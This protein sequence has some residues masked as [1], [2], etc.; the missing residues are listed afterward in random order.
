M[1]RFAIV[2]LTAGLI[3][4]S[5]SPAARAEEASADSVSWEGRMVALYPATWTQ[6]PGLPSPYAAPGGMET[7]TAV[8][9]DG[10]FT[11]VPVTLT[12]AQR[13]VDGEDFPVLAQTGLHDDA[14][15][16]QTR[17]ITG[18]TVAEITEL[19]K[20]GG[21][22]GSGFLAEDED[23]VS[24]LLADNRIV[25]GLGLT[26]P[27]L[28][29][30]LFH[31]I[32]VLDLDVGIVWRNH[33]WDGLEGFLYHGRMV[34]LKGTGTKG[35]QLSIFDDGIKGA[36]AIDFRRE[37]DPGEEAF[38]KSRYGQLPEDAF[39]HLVE[40]LS[41]VLTGEMEPQYIMRYG[42]YEGHTEWRTDPIALAFVFGLA[43]L[44]EIETAFPGRLDRVLTARF[45]SGGR[46][47][48]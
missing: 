47:G 2:L 15:L 18:R 11:V 5:V 34:R 27:R 26:H 7:V 46:D 41:R 24:V 14:T 39:A 1:S 33:S 21:L 29:A 8:L 40:K 31:L 35:G 42:F 4:L 28:A 16:V 37:L 17:T 12:P 45:D 3:V 36:Y 6:D 19:A 25:R 9:A 43:T 44:D 10:R 22:S 30:P 32:N 20:P 48:R 13:I 38:L 23:V